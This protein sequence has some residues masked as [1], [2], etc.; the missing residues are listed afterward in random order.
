MPSCEPTGRPRVWARRWRAAG[1]A[2]V[3]AAVT[4]V[5]EA[6][7]DL[8]GV[9]ERPPQRG[10][11]AD[12]A[13][14]N[15]K[16]A[17]PVLLPGVAEAYA[18]AQARRKAADERGEPLG[19]AKA[20][21]LPDGMPTMMETA[22]PI[23]ILQTRGK[24]TTINEFGTQ[25]R[26][27]YLDTRDHPPPDELEFNFFGDSVGW[28]EGDTLVVET[29]GV[30]TSTLLFQYAPHSERLKITERFRLLRPDFLELTLTMEDPQVLAEPWVVV[31]RFERRPGM[32]L[33][34][35]ICENQR[36]V[37]GPDGSIGWISKP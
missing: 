32:R 35:Y 24:I 34:E 33:R 9:W 14:V 13:K 19:S 29:I 3:L 6:A 36:T 5:A 10:P 20:M 26:H 22:L 37:V 2:L 28:W 23:E 7:P 31:R 21:C 17:P 30:Q 11:E 12:P 8:T 18:A 4:T 16:I 27:I 1:L 25:V 15:P